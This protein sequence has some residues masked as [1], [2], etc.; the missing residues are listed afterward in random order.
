M[1]VEAI[2]YRA[3]R[4]ERLGEE[5]RENLGTAPNPMLK[6]DK[7]SGALGLLF[8]LSGA[9]GAFRT[10]VKSEIGAIRTGLTDL[11]TAVNASEAARAAAVAA[12]AAKAKADADAAEAARKVDEARGGAP[13]SWWVRTA[14]APLVGLIVLAVGTAFGAFLAGHVVIR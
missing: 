6:D 4:G 11:T 8:E 2:D 10:E 13:K 12:A 14:V 3:R 9:L 7:G 1:S 5:V